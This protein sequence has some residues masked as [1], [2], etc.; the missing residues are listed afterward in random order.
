M[1]QQVCNRSVETNFFLILVFQEY[2][3]GSFYN[4]K[5]LLNEYLDTDPK[6]NEPSSLYTKV[7]L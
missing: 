3:L 2:H 7:K 4:I 1:T 5:E 6:T